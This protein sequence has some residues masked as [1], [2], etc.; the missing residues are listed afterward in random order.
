MIIESIE[1]IREIDYGNKANN[2]IKM[3]QENIRVPESWVIS[4]NYILRQIEKYLEI[5]PEEIADSYSRVVEFLENYPVELY[6]ELYNEV[7]EMLNGCEKKVRLVVRSSHLLEDGDNYSFSGLFTTEINISKPVNIVEAIIECWKKCFNES[8]LEYFYISNNQ[9]LLI[10]CAVLIQ[11]FIPSEVAGVMFKF[12]TNFCINSTWGMAKSIV[13]G[14]TGYDYWLLDKN[15]DEQD[16]INSKKDINIPVFSLTNPRVGEDMPFFLS[17]R[18]V[19]VKRFNNTNNFLYAQ[20]DDSLR[21]VR[22]LKQEQIAELVDLCISVS[23]K[24]NIA[25]CDIEWAYS[26]KTLYILQCRSIT[27]KMLSPTLN[28]EG[29]FLPLVGGVSRGACYFVSSE[30][31]AKAFPKGAIL[32]AKRLTGAVL[33]AASKASGCILESKSPLSHSAIIAREL[34]IPAVGAVEIKDIALGEIY[35]IDGEKGKIK[36]VVNATKMETNNVEKDFFYDWDDENVI[37]LQKFIADF[38]E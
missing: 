35:E 18:N 32:V 14:S 34:G 16:Y 22:S 1:Q 25:N 23:K 27:R 33:L 24:L 2:V 11:R 12:G 10:P 4:H 36:R 9:Q 38:S 31:E 30:S 13:D 19:K 26:K 28:G 3:F 29:D 21:V 37:K 15:G 17:E 8:I 6:S 7:K 5:S 20:L